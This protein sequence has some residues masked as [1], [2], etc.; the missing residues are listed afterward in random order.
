MHDPRVIV[1]LDFA[2]AP[3]AT[4]FVNTVSPARCRLKVGLELFTAAGPDFVRGLVTRGFKV[5]LDLKFHD[6]PNTV[7]QTCRQALTLGVDMLTVHCLGGPTMLAAARRG[8]GDG[9]GRPRVVGVTLL[10]SHGIEEVRAIGLDEDIEQR[11]RALAELAQ[12]AGLDGI[13]CAPTEAREMR[14]RFGPGFLL[15]TP[16]IRPA[17]NAP[18][19]QRRVL[20]PAEAIARG[21][22][23][24][25]IGRPITRAADPAASLAVIER[26]IG[27]S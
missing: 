7:E 8:V 20:T 24:L 4:A 2:S 22:D 9:P 12:T 25:V 3:E 13:V 1:A 10:T 14:R 5:F 11:T 21:A 26:E 27:A 17:G 19:D 18:D 15:V 6:I 23:L 16:G